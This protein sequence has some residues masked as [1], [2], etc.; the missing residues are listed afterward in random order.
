MARFQ[1][2]GV[3]A[4]ALNDWRKYREILRVDFEFR[5]AYCEMTEASVFGIGAFG[6]DHFRPKSRYPELD[7]TYSNLYYCCN[8][9]NRYKGAIWPSE[10]SSTR[11]YFFPDPCVCC[12]V[13]DH[14]ELNGEAFLVPSTRAG[15]FAIEVLGLNREVVC[16][17]VEDG[18]VSQLGSRSVEGVCQPLPRRIT[19]EF[20]WRRF[21]KNWRRSGGKFSSSGFWLD[22][23]RRE[24]G[25]RIGQ[26]VRRGCGL[27]RGCGRGL[28]EPAG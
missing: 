23:V 28:R 13:P 6:I 2:T 12:P 20:C 9:C 5:C 4:S 17:S 1:R 22:L 26:R 7:C 11:G 19:C 16:V 27:R 24:G 8:D 10:D 25:W 14:F 3:G 21:S 15:G 18:F